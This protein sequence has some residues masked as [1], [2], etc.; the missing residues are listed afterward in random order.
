MNTYIV[1]TTEGP[2]FV[3][4]ENSD[5][6]Y[7]AIAAKL[8]TENVYFVRT[9]NAFELSMAHKSNVTEAA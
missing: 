8:S 3:R 2:M 1:V 4:A 7:D 9:A 5:A 6:A